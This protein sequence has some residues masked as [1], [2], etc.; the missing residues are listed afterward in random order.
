M[1]QYEKNLI[2]M[3]SMPEKA[4]LKLLNADIRHGKPMQWDKHN[5]QNKRNFLLD[6]IKR[7]K[8]WKSA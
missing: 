5:V 4:H 6:E 2:Q 3:L 8:K 1:D 7:I